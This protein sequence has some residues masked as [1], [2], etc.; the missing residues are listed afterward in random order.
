MEKFVKGLDTVCW[1]IAL[2]L[3]I[4]RTILKIEPVPFYIAWFPWFIVHTVLMCMEYRNT[5]QKSL[6][7]FPI[8]F[9][10]FLLWG[11]VLRLT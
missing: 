7:L 11:C 6:L 8:I 1:A 3:F 4:L 2:I 9:V 10:V 5:K